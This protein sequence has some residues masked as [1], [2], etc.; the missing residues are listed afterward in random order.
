MTM[1]QQQSIPAG[2]STSMLMPVDW[3]SNQHLSFSVGINQCYDSGNPYLQ[4]YVI[5]KTFWR[6]D[7]SAHGVTSRSSSAK[8]DSATEETD[9]HIAQTLL[10]AC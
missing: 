6:Q 2:Q 3:L 4:L 9:S 7:C 10:T 5:G 8:Q 1:S